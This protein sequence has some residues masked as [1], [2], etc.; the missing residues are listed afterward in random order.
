MIHP[1]CPWRTARGLV[2][3]EMFETTPW[4][5]SRVIDDVALF[6]DPTGLPRNPV[7]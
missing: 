6:L 4:A 2:G 5:V 1:A 7:F 3:A